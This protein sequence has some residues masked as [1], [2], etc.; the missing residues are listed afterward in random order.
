M[1]KK[2]VKEIMES[3]EIIPVTYHGRSVVLNRYDED[4]NVAKV[5]PL[6]NLNSEFSVELSQL[7]DSFH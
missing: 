6:D 2:R 4:S 3:K 1:D 7:N 5:I